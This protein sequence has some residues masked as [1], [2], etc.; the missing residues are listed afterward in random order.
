MNL[1]N[2][3]NSNYQNNFSNFQCLQIYSFCLN[4]GNISWHIDHKKYQ[5]MNKKCSLI[6]SITYQHLAHLSSRSHIKFLMLLVCMNSNWLDIFHIYIN[7]SS[8]MYH[9]KYHKFKYQSQCMNFC[10]S[11]T[12]RYYSNIHTFYYLMDYFQKFNL[13]INMYRMN[14][15]LNNSNN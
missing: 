6:H 4:Q 10:N 15:C 7:Y 5:F 8:N 2:Q 9:S 14:L 13:L 3:Y 11:N 12:S 1:N